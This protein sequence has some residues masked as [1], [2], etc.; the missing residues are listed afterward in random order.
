MQ[1]WSAAMRLRT[2]MLL[3]RARREE[4]RCEM[5]EKMQAVEEAKSERRD[6]RMSTSRMAHNVPC[7][8]GRGWLAGSWKNCLDSKSGRE[9]KRAGERRE[10]HGRSVKVGTLRDARA[11]RFTASGQSSKRKS[12]IRTAG[13]HRAERLCCL[14]QSVAK[15]RGLAVEEFRAERRAAARR[16]GG[17]GAGFCHP[18][19]SR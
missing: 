4:R 8:E 5:V 1:H 3:Y 6:R 18:L 7:R 12:R 15:R 11:G 16:C 19:V 10:M 2:R 14:N 13:C 9:R 17:G